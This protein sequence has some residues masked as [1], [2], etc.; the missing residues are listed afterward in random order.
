[1]VLVAG[2]ALVLRPTG[3]SARTTVTA[4]FDNTNGLYVGDE[5]RILGVP[6]GKITR[7]EPQPGHVEVEFWFNSKHRVPVDVSAVVL[8]PSLVTARAIQ[9]TPA[10]T[11]GPTMADG[12]VIPQARTAVPVEWDDLR[13]QLQKLADSLQPTEPGGVSTLGAFVNTSADNLRGQGANIRDAVLNLSQALSILGD[14]SSDIFGSVRNVAVLVSALQSSTDL[15]EQLNT[16]LAGVTALFAND[17]DEVS[18]AIRDLNTAVGDVR[19]FVAENRETLGTTSDR[20]AAVTESVMDNMD[21]LKQILHI[22]PTAIQNFVNIYQPA[23][24][25]LSGVLAIGNFGDPIT[26]ICSAIQAASRLGAE[27]S[28]KLCVQY[29]A[30]IVKNRQY[31][32]LPLGMNPFVGAQARPNEITYSED[33]LRPDYVPPQAPSPAPDDPPALPAE[34]GTP[35]A[36]QGGSADLPAEAVATDPSDGLTG[37]MTP[38]GNGP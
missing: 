4:Y 34:Q 11:D 32:F 35:A 31:N 25:S 15:M 12:A 29:L 30:P 7:I 3:L 28:S 2:L 22:G 19:G 23:Q 9:L 37:M 1:M 6:V 38:P 5:V 8:S 27:Q 14:H 17:P 33:R 36:Q 16:N 20:V 18:A 26:F 10:Y 13:S 24:S 21:T